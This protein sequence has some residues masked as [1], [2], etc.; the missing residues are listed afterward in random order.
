MNSLPLICDHLR[1]LWIICFLSDKEAL[2]DLRLQFAEQI[3]R[4][5]D[6]GFLANRVFGDFALDG[7]HG[8]AGNFRQQRELVGGKAEHAQG[9]RK[10][11]ASRGSTSRP[12]ALLLRSRE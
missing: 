1:N 12:G 4:L 6:F 2:Q 9:T 3:Q 10:P 5:A 8:L 11:G 7:E